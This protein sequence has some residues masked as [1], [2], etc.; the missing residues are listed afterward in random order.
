VG[1]KKKEQ[2]ECRQPFSTCHVAG[3]TFLRQATMLA[4]ALSMRLSRLMFSNYSIKIA[5]LYSLDTVRDS[6]DSHNG[7]Y[8][9]E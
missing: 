4:T 8:G 5:A 9:T 1:R 3:V 6:R 7:W 2:G